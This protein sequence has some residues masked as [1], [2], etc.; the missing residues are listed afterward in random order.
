MVLER[1]WD[2]DFLKS[3]HSTVSYREVRSVITLRLELVIMLINFRVSLLLFISVTFAWCYHSDKDGAL[4]ERQQLVRKHLKRLKKQEGAIKL[5]GGRDEHEGNVEIFHSGKW[6]NI[7]DDEWDKYEAEVVCKQLNYHLGGKA[8]HSGIFGKARRKFW[9]DNLYCTGKEK[10]LADCRFDGWGQ[11][12]CDQSEAAGVVCTEEKEPEKIPEAKVKPPKFN[13][14]SKE[15]MKVRLVGGRVPTEG[16][17]EVKFGSGPYGDICG[18]GWSLLEANV[19]CKELNLGYANEAHQ[20]NFFGGSNG[21]HI[22]LTGTEC[23]GN[24]TKLSEC[25]FESF[26]QHEKCHGNKHH[27]AA[28]SCVVKMPD[29]VIDAT[30]L[31]TT[32]HLED[33]LMYFLTCAMEENCLASQ[34]YEIQKENQ[35]WHLETRRLLKFTAKVLNNGTDDFRPHIPKN[36]WEFHL[37]HM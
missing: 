6:G 35:N 18:D 28:V 25:M 15:S 26:G 5:V 27:V 20:T 22:L 37:C 23:V 9:M 34:A 8:T 3:S 16:R 33:R 2:R 30:E 21:T 14:K 13:Y 36:L 4:S 12:D 24:E 7:C 17:V 29:L 10:E 1:F 19:I 31:E 32:A 11:S